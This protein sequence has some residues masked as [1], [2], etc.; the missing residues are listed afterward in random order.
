MLVLVQKQKKRTLH[1]Q[2][3][4]IAM[5]RL[6]LFFA[7]SFFEKINKTLSLFLLVEFCRQKNRKTKNV[8]LCMYVPIDHPWGEC[9]Y[10]F[11]GQKYCQSCPKT[12]YSNYFSNIMQLLFKKIAIVQKVSIIDNKSVECTCRARFRARGIAVPREWTYT[13]DS[14]WSSSLRQL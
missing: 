14:P 11:G 6:G 13:S 2:L 1:L 10:F 9:W 12:M 4:S 5:I 7:E 3:R 8:T